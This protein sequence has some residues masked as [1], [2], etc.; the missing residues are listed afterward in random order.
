MG[1]KKIKK[2]YILDTDRPDHAVINKKLDKLDK[3]LQTEVITLFLKKLLLQND[4]DP[5][6]IVKKYIS[7]LN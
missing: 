5:N 7:D 2:V 1:S 6:I 4:E 3:G